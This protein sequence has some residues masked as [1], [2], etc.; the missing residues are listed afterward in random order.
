MFLPGAT[1][2]RHPG[3]GRSNGKGRLVSAQLG[4]ELVEGVAFGHEG[5]GSR[6]G[7]GQI[8]GEA[9]R[10][11]FEGGH[12]VSLSRRRERPGDGSAALGDDVGHASLAF[13]ETFCAPQPVSSVPGLGLGEG[14]FGTDDQVVKTR[15]LRAMGQLLARELGIGLLGALEPAPQ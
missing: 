4:C 10:L 6:L 7:G 14:G 1:G 2:A 8:G 9:G 15:Q 13:E 11:G 12:D 5:P 3:H